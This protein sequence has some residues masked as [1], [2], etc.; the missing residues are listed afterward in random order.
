M[1]ISD[2]SSDVCSSDLVGASSGPLPAGVTA[3]RWR[4]HSAA[5]AA[6]P[7]MLIISRL[8][9]AK[10]LTPFLPEPERPAAS[11]SGRGGG[12]AL[13]PAPRQS[14]PSGF[15]H[16]D[17]GPVI[18]DRGL[19]IFREV[20]RARAVL[21]IEANGDGSLEGQIGRAHV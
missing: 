16:G 14:A 18:D 6:A 2:W 4:G 21:V 10:T 9:L 1:R 20:D 11:G 17:G 5:N 3:P 8:L 13:S 15:A 19:T 12:R 7:P